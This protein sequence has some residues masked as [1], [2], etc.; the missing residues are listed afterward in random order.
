MNAEGYHVHV[1]GGHQARGLR[2]QARSARA[3][4]ISSTELTATEK[5]NTFLVSHG[6]RAP[7]WSGLF[8]AVMA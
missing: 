1:R 3:E 7:G 8:A 2:F 4:L 5:P 6:I